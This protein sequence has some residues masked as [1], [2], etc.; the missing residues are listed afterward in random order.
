MVVTRD[1]DL[2]VHGCKCVF[3]WNARYHKSSDLGGG[4]LYWRPYLS[5]MQKEGADWRFVG[6]NWDRFIETCVIAGCDYCAG[7]KGVGITTAMELMQEHS[8]MANVVR[9]IQ[10]DRVR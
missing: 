8:T 7:I 10:A 9:A 3:F 4:K 1:S 5:R 6:D 2:I